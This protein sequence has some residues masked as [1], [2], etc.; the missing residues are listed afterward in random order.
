[1]ASRRSRWIAP[2]TS[3]DYPRARIARS[4]PTSRRGQRLFYNGTKLPEREDLAT[5]VLFR[6]GVLET[7]DKRAT[8]MIKRP[9]ESDRA[10]LIESATGYWAKITQ[11]DRRGADRHTR[12]GERIVG[13]WHAEGRVDALLC[14]LLEHASEEVRY[15][16]AAH[17]FSLN[18][19][20]E[21]PVA[22]LEELAKNPAGLVA[23]TA[24]LLLQS[25]P[26]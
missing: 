11:G 20:R 18:L 9:L 26:R 5:T 15:A 19:A 6:H 21:V 17:L 10:E 1:M 8:L 3:Y 2:T 4:V 14:P 13:R 24:R 7:S 16:A 22:V 12:A 23:P 25:R